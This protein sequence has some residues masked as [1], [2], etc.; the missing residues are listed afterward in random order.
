MSLTF[1]FTDEQVDE[2]AARVARLLPER[3]LERLLTVDQLADFLQTSTDWVRYHQAELGGY[4]LSGKGSGRNPI[5]FRVSDVEKFLAERRLS[6]PAR[7]GSGF[8]RGDPNWA[9]GPT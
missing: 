6:P 1:E 3:D 2:L 5:R 8:S 7:S 9:M 4:R